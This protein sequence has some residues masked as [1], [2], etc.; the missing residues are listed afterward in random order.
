VADGVVAV[1]D[2]AIGALIEPR[3]GGLRVLVTRR[4]ATTVYAGW[5]ELPGGKVRPD[6]TPAAALVREFGEEVDLAIEVGA[7]LPIVEHVYPHGHVRL[8]PFYCRLAHRP[9]TPRNVHVADHRWV[10]PA[11]LLK[12]KLPEANEPI[13]RRIIADHG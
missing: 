8:H 11:E 4:P 12:M 2:V 9:Q 7:A 1:V 3:D 6:E 10:A 13:T 5:W